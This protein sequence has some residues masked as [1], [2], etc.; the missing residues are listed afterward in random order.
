MKNKKNHI[1]VL[2]TLSIASSD[3]REDTLSSVIIRTIYVNESINLKN[4]SK[5]IKKEFDFIPYNEEL[6][7]LVEKLKK[8]DKI[9]ASGDILTLTEE[10]KQEVLKLETSLSDKDEARFQNF[11]NFILDDLEEEIS[12]KQIKLLWLTFLKY[13]YH[14]FYEYGHEAIKTLH[15]HMEG[16]KES[17]SYEDIL[18]KFIIELKVKDKSIT[19]IFKKVVERFPDFASEKDLDFLNDL[20][21][22]TLSFTSLGLK[23][24]LADSTINHDLV[25]WVLYLDTNVLYSILGL[26]SHPENQACIALFNLVR[27]NSDYIKIKLRYTEQTYKELGSKKSDFDLLDDKMTD[28]SIKALLK[29]EKLDDFSAKFYEDILN[30]RESTIHP[31]K[32]IELSQRTLKKDFIEISRTAKRLEKIGEKYIDTRISDY[33]KFLDLYIRN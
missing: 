32:V 8:I 13:L 18:Q 26:H 6:F 22:K 33:F 2:K 28:A 24:E 23:P 10:Q 16:E 5:K 7:P 25:D 1:Q 31:S 14:S 4:L 15:P 29:S 12:I 19:N 20:A 9:T 21:Q 3:T 17:N 11:K 27:S 30:R